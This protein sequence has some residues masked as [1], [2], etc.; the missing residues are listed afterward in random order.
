M[1][2]GGKKDSVVEEAVKEETQKTDSSINPKE[3]FPDSLPE[4]EHQP[5]EPE[6]PVTD[7]LDLA[8]DEEETEKTVEEAGVLQRK[9]KPR[10]KVSERFVDFFRKCYNKWK[11]ILN[12]LKR[13]ARKGT[14]ILDLLEDEQLRRAA[15]RIKGYFLR[16]A[17]YLMPQKLEAGSYSAWKIRQIR[18]RSWLD[19]RCHAAVWRPS[20]CDAGFYP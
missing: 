8:W 19:C 10:K 13:L 16:G 1:L 18:G 11:N 9:E 4:P 2:G 6:G 17:G 15:V 7:I 14:S 12:K 5:G 20:G 3:R